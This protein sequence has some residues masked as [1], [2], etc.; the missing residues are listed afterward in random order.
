MN[1]L[2]QQ[3][4]VYLSTKPSISSVTHL[5]PSD[6]PVSILMKDI[7]TTAA[8]RQLE[9]VLHQTLPS[10]RLERSAIPLCPSVELALL[11][12]EL[13]QTPLPDEELRQ[14]LASPAYWCFCWASGQVLAQYLLAH[15][16]RVAGKSVLDFG[17]GSGVVGIAAMLAGAREVLAVDL[18]PAALAACAVNAAI[19]GVQLT[20]AHN[21]DTVQSPIDLIIAADVLYDRDNLHFLDSLPTLA[22]DVLIADSRI[23][24]FNHPQYRLLQTQT[25]TTWPDLEEHPEYNQVRVFEH[26]R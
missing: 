12:T 3:I 17:A 25:A 9:S 8:F 6:Q 16:E 13:P 20:R 22:T 7:A 4:I 26:T 1:T 19:N 15:P 2:A 11:Q 10:C 23:K 5:D 18:D 21:L 24:N 14:V